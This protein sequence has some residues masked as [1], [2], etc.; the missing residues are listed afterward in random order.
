MGPFATERLL[1]LGLVSVTAFLRTAYA[2]FVAILEPSLLPAL[3]GAFLEA[4][5]GAAA[6]FD[7][8]AFLS[9]AGAAGFFSGDFEV[10]GF[11]FSG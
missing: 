3:A 6:G 10:A 4:A 8:D 7:L 1:A 5:A 11:F 2:T 9:C